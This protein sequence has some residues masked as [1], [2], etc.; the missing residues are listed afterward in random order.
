[1]DT[2]KLRAEVCT[3]IEAL[4]GRSVLPSE[5]LRSIGVDSI[6]FLE[7]V[8]FLEKQLGIPLPLQLLTAHP[9]TTV[10]ALLEHIVT[11]TA[12]GQGVAS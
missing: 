6:A 1:M 10:Q 5:D 11:L 8:I 12:S 4:V 2:D 3:F 9:L 7:L